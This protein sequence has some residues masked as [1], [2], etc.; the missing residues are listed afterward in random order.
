MSQL[1]QINSWM[2]TH[3]SN[4][5]KIASGPTQHHSFI[6]AHLPSSKLKI[7][8][9]NGHIKP[10]PVTRSLRIMLH[11]QTAY[12]LCSQLGLLRD[13]SLPGNSNFDAYAS[14]GRNS[15]RK[16]HLLPTFENNYFYSPEQL[17]KAAYRYGLVLAGKENIHQLGFSLP[18]EH[19]LPAERALLGMMASLF[20]YW[21]A[22]HTAQPQQIIL[23][24]GD[25]ADSY[26][27]SSFI[28]ERFFENPERL[29][30]EYK[31][32]PIIADLSFNPQIIDIDIEEQI[33]CDFAV[34]TRYDTFGEFRVDPNDT[35]DSDERAYVRFTYGNDGNFSVYIAASSEEKARRIG[36]ALMTTMNGKKH[37][38]FNNWDDSS[39]Y[40][41]VD[42]NHLHMSIDRKDKRGSI[43]FPDKMEDDFILRIYPKPL[44]QESA[45]KRVLTALVDKHGLVLGAII[46]LE[47]DDN[48]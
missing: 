9:L 1:S 27:R 20:E 35:S 11:K 29:T 39:S 8:P 43:S 5:F 24:A 17:T 2:I 19:Y 4:A 25:E 21:Q 36:G 40:N 3:S 37:D 28:F 44:S 31:D 47:R 22:D 23:A 41:H 33:A 26:K 10:H 46:N 42:D 34:L 45:A 30:S 7:L 15:R 18:P 6:M 32:R 12:F 48:H 14:R 16:I 38:Y 13:V